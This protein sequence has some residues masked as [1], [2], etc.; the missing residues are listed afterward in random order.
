M[1]RHI[2]SMNAMV[3]YV[4]IRCVMVMDVREMHVCADM[5]RQGIIGQCT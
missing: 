5:S 4:R 1:V 3:R 2:R